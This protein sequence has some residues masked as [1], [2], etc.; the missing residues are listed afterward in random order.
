MGHHH[1]ASY[2][3]DD[4]TAVLPYNT[5]LECPDVSNLGA[6]ASLHTSRHTQR[7]PPCKVPAALSRAAHEA[8]ALLPR[9]RALGLLQSHRWPVQSSLP[10]DQLLLPALWAA[11]PPGAGITAVE[12]DI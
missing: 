9:P 10:A 11:P 3:S 5:L 12:R 2:P 8:M 7:C 1:Q 6:T 4:E